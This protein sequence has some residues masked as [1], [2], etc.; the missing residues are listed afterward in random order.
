MASRLSA[1]PIMPSHF[2]RVTSC[3]SLA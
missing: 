3:P 1:H 2:S